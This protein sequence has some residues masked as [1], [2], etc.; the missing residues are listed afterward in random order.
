MGRVICDHDR[1]KCCVPFRIWGGGKKE[2]VSQKGGGEVKFVAGVIRRK[3]RKL[4]KKGK[5]ASFSEKSTAGRTEKKSTNFGDQQG[6]K[7][8]K[9][10]LKKRRPAARKRTT[11]LLQKKRKGKE[12]LR[13]QTP[14]LLGIFHLHPQEGRFSE[15]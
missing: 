12:E 1:K 9:R 15:C 13:R 8:K 3:G 4:W 10:L 7:E 11:S 2:I 5:A 6:K 14:I